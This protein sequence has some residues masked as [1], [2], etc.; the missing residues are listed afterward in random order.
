MPLQL[1]IGSMLK[2]RSSIS[3][4]KYRWRE[5]FYLLNASTIKQIVKG[6]ILR[7]TIGSFSLEAVFH[8]LTICL[9]QMSL[10]VI[11]SQASKTTCP[12]WVTPLERRQMG[13]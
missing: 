12:M 9:G 4:S 1:A 7:G 6:T 5:R 3:E 2:R 13:L 11:E 10:T 8:D